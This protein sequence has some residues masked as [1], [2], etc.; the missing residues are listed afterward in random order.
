MGDF[1]VIRDKLEQFIKRF[2]GN[3]LLKGAILFVAIG[4]LYFMFTLFVEYMLWLEP[5]ERTIL[6][7]AFIAI[8]LIL[9]G[10]LIVFP[11]MKLLK[12][13]K[14]LSYEDASKII[15]NHFPQVNDKLLNVLQLTNNKID[16]ELLLAS[17]D[18]K[19]KELK[20]IPF[21]LA[22]NLRK[23]IKYVKY[24]AIPFFIFLIS[25]LTGNSEWFKDSYVRVVHY[26][27]AYEPPAPFQ[28]FI[29]NE[30][31]NATENRDFRLNIK[32]AG[33]V[34]PEN[35]QIQYNDRYFFLQQLAPGEFEYTFSQ[36]QDNVEFHLV[37]N[38]IK[39]R[40]YELNVIKTP[41]LLNF[42]MHLDYP[43]YLNKESEVL[44]STGNAIVPEG[45]KVTWSA[46]TKSTDDVTI[47]SSDTLTFLKMAKNN[48][49]ASKQ[50]HNNFEYTIS[51][52]N[53]A[54]K[55]YEN[56]SFSIRVIKDDYPELSVEVEKDSIDT[57][58][59]YFWGQVSDDYGLNRLQLVYYPYGE[60]E[61]VSQIEIPISKSNFDEFIIS[62]PNRLDLMEGVS[63]E[64]FFQAFD[65]DAL[66]NFKSVKSN[67]F[68][69]KKLTKDEEENKRLS[70]QNE[71]IK[72]IEKT[73]NRL[74]EQ[75]K[76]LEELSKIQKEKQELNFNDKKKFENF[77]R[78]Q[79]QQEELMRN[80]NKEIRENIEKIG[81]R[82]EED[83]S[84]REDLLERIRENENQLKKDE[85]LLKE[86]EK[87]QEKIQREEFAEKLE[88]LAK[89]SKNKERSLKQLI[90]L[91]KRYYVSKKAEKLG[92][93]LEEL[94][95]EQNKLSEESKENNTKEDQ[96]RLNNAFED[97]QKELDE[98]QKDNKALQKPIPIP[99]DKITEEEI[100]DEQKE[101]YKELN[102]SEENK[103]NGNEKDSEKNRNA[104]KKKQKS[105]A[106][107]MK[108]LSE[109]M[110]MSMNMGGMDQLAEDAEMLR[111][112]LDNLVLFSFDQ[113]KLMNTFRT[114]DINSNEYSKFLRNQNSLREHFEHIDDS[115]FALSLRQPKISEE[116]NRQI[117]EVFFN[118]DKTLTQLTENQIY[119]GVASQQYTLTAANFL[120]SFLSDILDNIEAQMSMMPGKGQGEQDIQLPDIIMSQEELNKEMEDGLK[121]AE[122]SQNSNKSDKELKNNL[123]GN[124]KGHG[125]TNSEDINGE[126]LEIFKKQQELKNALRDRIGNREE[127]GELENILKDME[128]IELDLINKGFTQE[129]FQKMKDLK[130]EL[131]K[132]E[133]ASFTQGL[134]NKRQSE[135]NYD[136]FVN[137]I[138]ELEL[139]KKDYF[140]TIEILNR[141]VLP[142]KEAYK[143][144]TQRYFKKI[145]D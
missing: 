83:D 126:L 67:V 121:N 57:Q 89:Q 107:K 16:S 41:I 137:E 49:E 116:I 46:I 145:N 22:I 109:G 96:E 88:E 143:I 11:L 20:P 10:K 73:Y 132:L 136:R 138:N 104:A 61:K 12:L 50:L 32:T 101:A 127:N 37:A 19:S 23:N 31:L 123:D 68:S 53:D 91:T 54:L 6:F 25:V 9:L 62:F 18:Q 90:E 141:Q 21:K 105:A 45:T 4:L 97:L 92:Q 140:N 51:T 102:E 1:L 98:L 7:W 70:E 64:L 82:N 35:V 103:N 30:D 27:T 87:I 65:N 124:K 13:K 84:F 29:T 133:N 39:S 43:S 26:R 119:Q 99:R 2:Y 129:T 115:L 14:G 79:Q 81:E 122:N 66:H 135:T 77:L 33:E 78:R 47:Y 5:L 108:K 142:M 58:T 75:D 120:A 144:K 100:K 8:E 42:E 113:E 48:F 139:V 52:S 44:K 28:F 128:D 56:L 112:I 76:E 55:D 111:Q 85:Q 17:I 38:N 15:G 60:E 93:E 118:I 86:L 130:Y 110:K 24:T 63:Y 95:K 40:R 34:I 94:S 59:L 74:K 117:T 134:D 114:I 106:N 80:F 3:E 125:E 72:D 131:L 36:P 71:T 69:Y